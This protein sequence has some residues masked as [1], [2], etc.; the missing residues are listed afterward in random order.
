M[1]NLCEKC[2]ARFT[3]GLCPYCA[4]V[5]ED[6]AGTVGR[7]LA[8]IIARAEVRAESAQAGAA[9]GSSTAARSGPPSA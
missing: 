5:L 4:A 7:D 2:S 8:P 6:A 9:G 1:A 3:G